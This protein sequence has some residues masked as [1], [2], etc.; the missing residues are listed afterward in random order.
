MSNRTYVCLEC[1]FS[2]RADAAYGLETE[3]RCPH[4]HES[5]SELPWRWRI[6]KRTDNP[7]WKKLKQMILELEKE[8]IPK[9]KIEG[10]KLLRKIEKQIE[11]I[12]RQKDFDDKEKKLK[13]LRWKRREIKKRYLN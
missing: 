8:W 13:Y 6:P 11:S 1:R 5:L 7:E 4:C 2:K 12:L 3:Y 9:R 10:D